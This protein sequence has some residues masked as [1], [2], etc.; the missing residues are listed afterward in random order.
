MYISVTR[1]IG[2]NAIFNWIEYGAATLWCRLISD[3]AGGISLH[4]HINRGNEPLYNF[5][6]NDNRAKENS[7]NIVYGDFVDK[8]YATIVANH[9]YVSPGQKPE[10]KY[11]SHFCKGKMVKIVSF[12]FRNN[13]FRKSM[14]RMGRYTNLCGM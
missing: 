2:E 9:N 11:R 8:T 4:H 14:D 6:L 3:E 13:F 12:F 10:E 5:L 1:N 7:I